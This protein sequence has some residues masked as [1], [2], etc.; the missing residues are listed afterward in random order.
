[1][2]NKIL[3]GDV[4]LQSKTEAEWLNGTTALPN[5]KVGIVSDKKYFV[6]GNNTDEFSVLDKYIPKNQVIDL[7]LTATEL[8]HLG[9]FHLWPTD[10]AN[11]PEGWTLADGKDLLRQDFYELWSLAV[12]KE[13]VK[14]ESEWQEIF[15]N[16][17]Y[18]PY[19]S[20]GD[21][22]ITF[23]IPSIQ[24]ANLASFKW[25]VSL[26]DKA[27]VFTRLYCGRPDAYCGAEGL[28]TSKFI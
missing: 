10:L 8:H 16:N 27:S 20:S 17:G 9:V 5:G 14:T 24:S 22:S 19:Y 6:I 7:A 13:W 1:M 23:R 28:H 2:S 3:L 4:F 11:P 15:T 12:Y 21:G 25:M 26:D 18:C